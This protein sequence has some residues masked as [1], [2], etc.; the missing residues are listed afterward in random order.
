MGS[1]DHLTDEEYLNHPKITSLNK[2]HRIM[3]NIVKNIRAQQEAEKKKVE[4][5]TFYQKAKAMICSPSHEGKTDYAYL[6]SLN[7]RTVGCGNNVNT[8][9]RYNNINWYKPDGFLPTENEKKEGFN[10]F[11]PHFNKGYKAEYFKNVSDLRISEEE[12]DRLFH[13]QYD[14]NISRIK[15]YIPNYDSFPENTRLGLFSHAYNL[16]PKSYS[17]FNNMFNALQKGDL[18]TAAKES[19]YKGASRERV[20][21]IQRLIRNK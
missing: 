18:E 20:A 8:W 1:Y 3:T 19:Q 5:D 17:K 11:N 13:T 15:K 12:I 10:S 2:T 7:L 16:K 21:E 6:D 14:Q 4:K 9:D